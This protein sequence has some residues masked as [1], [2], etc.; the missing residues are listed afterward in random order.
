VSLCVGF[1]GQSFIPSLADPTRPGHYVLK[2]EY[3]RAGLS[4]TH[5]WHA[6]DGSAILRENAPPH[7]TDRWWWDLEKALPGPQLTHTL[8]KINAAPIKPT[9]IV[10]AQGEG[11]SSSPNPENRTR[12][13]LAT[14]QVIWRLKLACAGNNSTAASAIPTFTHRIGR[15]INTNPARGVQ[16][17]RDAQIDLDNQS[18][19]VR[20]LA[21]TWDLELLGDDPLGR[22]PSNSHMT[23][24]GDCVWSWR[25]AQ[26]LLA[27]LNR[28]ALVG[29]RLAGIN[30]VSESAV[31]VTFAVH[32]SLALAHVPTIEA[33]AIRSA[34]GVAEKM[35]LTFEWVSPLTVR[36]ISPFNLN[37]SEILHPFGQLHNVNRGHI[38]RDTMGTVVNTFRSAI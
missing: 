28:P 1:F 13:R 33:F 29:P 21:D 14:A 37:G 5:V 8:A 7:A 3:L 27:H 35:D 36:V 24:L 17:I 9:L 4:F 30:R 6:S 20:F 25:V 12:H 32:P 22:Y 15:R 10:W 23:E 38:L 26:T 19:T 34:A 16:I 31:D 2:R 11:D 18:P